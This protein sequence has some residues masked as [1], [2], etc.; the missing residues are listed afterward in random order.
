MVVVVLGETLLKRTGE[1]YP[2]SVCS[3]LCSQ[4]SAYRMHTNV[5]Y[6]DHP[7]AVEELNK[8]NHTQIKID[9]YRLFFSPAYIKFMCYPSKHN[10]RNGKC[11]CPIKM[12]GP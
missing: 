1:L 2:Q 11:S 7:Q 6:C 5:T 10:M 12:H 9:D 4:K 8:N 3:Y